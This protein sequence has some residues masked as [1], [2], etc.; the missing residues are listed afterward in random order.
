MVGDAKF[1]YVARSIMSGPAS[2]PWEVDCRTVKQKLDAGEAFLLL[3]CREKSEYDTVRIAGATLLPMSELTTRA[4]EIEAHRN[5]PIVVHCHH[6]GRSM[7]V[8]QWLRQNGFAQAQSM[9]GGIHQW[10][11]DI[12]PGMVKY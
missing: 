6:G 7:R 9:A 8:A 1:V 11:E 3:D 5:G 12:E 10:A 4:K 2:L